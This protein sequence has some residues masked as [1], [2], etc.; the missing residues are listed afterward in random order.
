MHLFLQSSKLRRAQHISVFFGTKPHWYDCKC[1]FGLTKSR[2][3]VLQ[4]SS[5]N[6]KT[7]LW[8]ASQQQSVLQTLEEVSSLSDPPKV[9]G[10]VRVPLSHLIV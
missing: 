8:G 9:E 6:S 3:L 7:S 4:Y 10:I 2:F 5:L 1:L